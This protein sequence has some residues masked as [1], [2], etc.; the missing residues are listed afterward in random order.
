MSNMKRKHKFLDELRNH[1]NKLNK[2]VAI[3]NYCYMPISKKEIADLKFECA[4]EY[5]SYIIDKLSY[6]KGLLKVTNSELFQMFKNCYDLYGSFSLEQKHCSKN[7]YYIND[8]FVQYF[9]IGKIKEMEIM[10]NRISFISDTSTVVFL[11]KD[12]SF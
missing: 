9:R 2:I 3:Y 1:N 5:F 7:G 4:S 12:I 8:F 10:G 11:N 6:S